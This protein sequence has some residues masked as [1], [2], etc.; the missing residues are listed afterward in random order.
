[1]EESRDAQISHN[2]YKK[3]GNRYYLYDSCGIL[4]S[5]SKYVAIVFLVGKKGEVKFIHYGNPYAVNV[6]MQEVIREGGES[7]VSFCADNWEVNDLNRLIRDDAYALEFHT[8]L[9]REGKE[10]RLSTPT[11]S[12]F[13]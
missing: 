8:K 2:Y 7:V 10:W 13:D 3:I 4:L 5:I 12:S 11:S 9:L 1:M 6:K